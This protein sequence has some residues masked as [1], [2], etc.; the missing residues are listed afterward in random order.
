[1]RHLLVSPEAAFLRNF[2]ARRGFRDGRVGLIVSLLNSYY[3]LLKYVKLWEIQQRVDHPEP[4]TA[5]PRHT[6]HGR[7]N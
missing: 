2:V 5:S 6:P 4:E 7:T 1:V 3:V